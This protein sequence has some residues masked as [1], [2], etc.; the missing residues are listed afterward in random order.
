MATTAVPS[1]AVLDLV[2]AHRPRREIA[3]AAQRVL[4]ARRDGPADLASACEQALAAATG[5]AADAS[6]AA[7]AARAIAAAVERH[8]ESFPPGGEPAYHDRHH[9]AETILA[10]G[11]L[12][13]LARQL[14][15]MDAHEA[16]TAVAAM[17]GHDLLHDGSVAGPRGVLEQRSAD[18]SAAIAA[19]EGLDADGIAMIRRMIA[20]TTWP[21]RDSEASDLPCRLAREADLFAS[22]LPDLGPRLARRLLTELAAAGQ[23]DAGMVASHASRLG[24]LRMLPTP[25]PPAT[26]LGLDVTRHDQLEAYGGVARSLGLAPATADA[27]AAAL[28]ELDRADAEALL[29]AAAPAS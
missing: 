5:A 15:R 28:D 11:W 17:A 23:Q 19:A 7:R 26:L 29:A 2:A 12:A 24:L 22:A 4:S 9:Q 25:S 20:A 16:A 1:L 10:M 13:G 18:A 3:S 6:P 27:A 14:G 8:G 21:W